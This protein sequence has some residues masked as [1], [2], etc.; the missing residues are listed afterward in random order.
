V[1][2]VAEY[3]GIAIAN[4]FTVVG[5]ERFVIG[6]GIAAAGDL[7]LDPIRAATRRRAT[8]LDPESIRI[9]PASLGSAAGAIGAALAA[10]D[11]RG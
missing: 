10:A 3:L 4:V 7:I 2:R 11:G 9:V 1:D 8:L 5:P 6:G